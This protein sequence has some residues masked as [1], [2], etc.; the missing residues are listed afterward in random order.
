MAD[1]GA[2]CWGVGARGWD[3]PAWVGSLYP[4]DLPSDWRLAYY[5]NEF[6]VVM[7]EQAGWLAV[8]DFSS[9]GWADDVPDEFRFFLELELATAVECGRRR[10]VDRATTALGG[11]LG[12]LLISGSPRVRRELMQDILGSGIGLPGLFFEDQLDAAHTPTQEVPRMFRSV[13]GESGAACVAAIDGGRVE[14]LRELRAEI[15]LVSR[16][17]GRDEVRAVFL[18]GDPPDPEMLRGARTLVDLV[19]G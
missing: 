8:E 9:L 2:A 6:S 7:V 11:L 5:A 3:H 4:T 19:I 10:L 18:T 17:A 14:S 12:G 15:D 13:G 16:N 1:G